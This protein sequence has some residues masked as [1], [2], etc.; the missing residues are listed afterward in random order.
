MLSRSIDVAELLGCHHELSRLLTPTVEYLIAEL[1]EGSNELA[2]K[3]EFTHPSPKRKRD[4]DDPA[5]AEE[6]EIT[7]E[8]PPPSPKRIREEKEDAIMLRVSG[9]GKLFGCHTVEYIIS[10]LFLCALNTKE[11]WPEFIP[12]KTGIWKDED[13]LDFWHEIWLT[14]FLNDKTADID[15][16][17]PDRFNWCC[18]ET[19]SEPIPYN[20]NITHTISFSLESPPS[21]C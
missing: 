8:D 20:V 10:H 16:M 5:S 21:F 2:T 13:Q 1:I 11:N 18:R 4:D 9:V 14:M 6:G 19:P 17:F 15:D 3:M 12:A 7:Q